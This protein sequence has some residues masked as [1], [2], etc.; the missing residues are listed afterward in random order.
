LLPLFAVTVY[1]TSPLPVPEAPEVTDT[2]PELL[3]AVHAQ[4][5]GALTFTLPLPPTTPKVAL[6]ADNE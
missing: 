2:N 3:T 6:A 4:P 1:D 5:A